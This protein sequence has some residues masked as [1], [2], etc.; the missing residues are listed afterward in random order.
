[1][2]LSLVTSSDEIDTNRGARENDDEAAVAAGGGREKKKKQKA[3]A[4]RIR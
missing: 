4:V 3:K 1:M 2:S